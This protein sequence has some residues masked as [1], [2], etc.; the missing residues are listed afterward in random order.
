MEAKLFV[1]VLLFPFHCHSKVITIFC[2]VIIKCLNIGAKALITYIHKKQLP[3]WIISIISEFVIYGR[4]LNMSKNN[5]NF[6][7]LPSSALGNESPLAEAVLP[8]AE[9]LEAPGFWTFLG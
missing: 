3:G 6:L 2:L 8:V 4:N 5:L 1:S 7:L 9:A